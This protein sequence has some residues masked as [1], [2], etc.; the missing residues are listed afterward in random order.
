MAT[1][2]HC[3]APD[4]TVAVTPYRADQSEKLFNNNVA[5][6]TVEGYY[7][8]PAYTGAVDDPNDVALIVVAEPSENVVPLAAAA[9]DAY[10]PV[11]L[12]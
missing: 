9:P 8:H 1:A 6:L 3:A 7:P 4:E 2:A 10:P 11:W 12:I 5:P